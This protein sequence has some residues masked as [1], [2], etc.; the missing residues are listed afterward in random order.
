MFVGYDDSHVLALG[1]KSLHDTFLECDDVNI[2]LCE[3][4]VARIRIYNE[5][6]ISYISLPS[7]RLKRRPLFQNINNQKQQNLSNTT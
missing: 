6:S 5:P 3:L 4:H 7:P 2:K 1:E